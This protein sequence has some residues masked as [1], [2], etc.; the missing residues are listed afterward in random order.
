MTTSVTT[1]NTNNTENNQNNFVI[2]ASKLELPPASFYVNNTE[3]RL[4]SKP[5]KK[6]NPNG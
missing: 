4:H 1:V 6:K 2:R 3:Q 5:L